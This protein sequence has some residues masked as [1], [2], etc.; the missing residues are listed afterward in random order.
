LIS[1]E[2]TDNRFDYNTDN[3]PEGN[4]TFRFQVLDS[5]GKSID[6]FYPRLKVAA[7]DIW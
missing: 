1:S 5:N 3:L 6:A 7:R 4:Y 2:I